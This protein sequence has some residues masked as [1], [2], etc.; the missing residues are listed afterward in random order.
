M[1]FG[2]SVREPF[3]ALVVEVGQ[4][5]LGELGLGEAGW[6]EPVVAEGDEVSGGDVR[7]ACDRADPS[8]AGGA[9]HR[10]W[11]PASSGVLG[12]AVSIGRGCQS[13]PSVPWA[14]FVP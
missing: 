8:I 6:V 4:G 1:H 9:L 13:Q 2:V 14:A 12:T 5:S 3:R 10:P 11:A 7:S